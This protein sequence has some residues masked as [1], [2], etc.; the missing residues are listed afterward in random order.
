MSVMNSK[1]VWGLPARVIHWVMA[2]MIFG[3]LGVGSYMTDLP[4]GFERIEMT[5]THK[6]VGFVVFT[7]AVLRVLWRFANRTSPELPEEMPSWQKRASHWSHRALYVL[8]F[9]MPLSGW[10]MST[11]SPLNDPD[12]YPVQI[13]NQVFGLFEMPDPFPTGNE[14]LSDFF[15][16]VH[17]YTALVLAILVVVHILAALK[18]HL[19]DK[20]RILMRMI[21]GKG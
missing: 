11:A 15:A 4:I 14:A 8:I 5:Q 9:L 7:L 3:L 13:K 10:L 19:I 17:E 1:S 20:D 2:L 12:A 21:S 16:T 6:S 18:H